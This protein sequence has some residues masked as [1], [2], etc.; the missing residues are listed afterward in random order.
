MDVSVVVA[1]V[2]VGALLFV[3]RA[4]KTDAGSSS[5]LVTTWARYAKAHKMRFVAPGMLLGERTPLLVKERD[6]GLVVRLDIASDRSGDTRAFFTRIT[7]QSKLPQATRFR[8]EARSA[9]LAENLTALTTLDEDFDEDFALTADTDESAH[10]AARLVTGDVRDAL[11]ALGGRRGVRLDYD[12]GEIALSWRGAEE[13]ES[14]LDRGV[15]AV[16]ALAHP[17]ERHAAYR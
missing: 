11:I 4:F 10:L 6:D 8:V 1:L 7:T 12:H 14:M 5:K 9:D 13:D 2:S 15:E 16:L 3:F 17:R